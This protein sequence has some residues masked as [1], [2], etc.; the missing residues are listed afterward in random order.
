MAAR[1]TEFPKAATDRAGTVHL[2][3][4]TDGADCANMA[5]GTPE[6]V[7][8]AE[9]WGTLAR[10]SHPAEANENATEIV[11]VRALLE[12]FISSLP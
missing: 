5:G 6:P 4:R 3:V 7:K 2:S 9:D 12:V 8:T 1:A 11:R 10:R